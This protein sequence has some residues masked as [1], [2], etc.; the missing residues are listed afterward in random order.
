MLD[1]IVSIHDEFITQIVPKVQGIKQGIPLQVCG[2]DGQVE[3]GSLIMP[4][5]MDIVQKLVNDA[6]KKGATLHCG[7]TSNPNVNGQFFQPTVL[8]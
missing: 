2:S 4:A 7:G 8:R 1:K 6:V 5:Q 3:C